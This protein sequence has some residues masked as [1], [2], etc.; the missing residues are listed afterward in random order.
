MIQLTI[1]LFLYQCWS[2]CQDLLLKTFTRPERP[3]NN[4]GISRCYQSSSAWQTTRRWWY[5]SQTAQ[6]RWFPC[7]STLQHS[8]HVLEWRL[9]SENNEGDQVCD[10][11]ETQRWKRS[12]QQLQRSFT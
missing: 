10:S 4:W 12:L 5:C 9:F 6:L 8:L 3:S 2:N 7:S 11:V 1:S